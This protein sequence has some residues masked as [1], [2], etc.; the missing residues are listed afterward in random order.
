MFENTRIQTQGKGYDEI[1]YHRWADDIVI[2]I[3][4][5]PSKEW[6]VN[7]AKRRLSEELEKL[8]VKMNMDKTKIA[9]IHKGE[10][11]G[12]LGFDFRKVTGRTGKQFVR[13]GSTIIKFSIK[14]VAYKISW[15]LLGGYVKPEKDDNEYLTYPR[16]SR[17][18]FTISG[19]IM[20]I[21]ILPMLC[22]I[23][24]NIYQKETIN[25]FSQY[26]NMFRYIYYHPLK[27][28]YN[29]IMI[30][31]TITFANKYLIYYKLF[32]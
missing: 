3:N 32:K 2:I 12:Y 30:F 28:F 26:A 13:F 6:L 19:L 18:I 29:G 5:H 14:G 7:R 1:N 22:I 21:F 24:I 20:S 9:Y 15:I 17:I 25:I 11:F 16:I 31:P 8:Q 10:S 23:F 4:P 27:Y